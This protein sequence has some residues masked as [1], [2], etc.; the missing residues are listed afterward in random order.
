MTT[1]LAILTV[2][3]AISIVT[4]MTGFTNKVNLGLK[5]FRNI[6]SSPVNFVLPENVSL[7]ND[8]T[9]LQKA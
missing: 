5:H 4:L 9:M 8:Y 3:L 7:T 6:T 2:P 1:S